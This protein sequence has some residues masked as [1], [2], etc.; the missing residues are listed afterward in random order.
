MAAESGVMW[1][2]EGEA[3]RPLWCIRRSS[4]RVGSCGG[5][6]VRI[7]GGRFAAKGSPRHGNVRVKGLN[8]R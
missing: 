1:I 8:R 4:E 7:Q 2:T 6:N 3:P 5:A